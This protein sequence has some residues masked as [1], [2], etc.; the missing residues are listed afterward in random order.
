MCATSLTASLEGR[1]AESDLPG[2]DYTPYFFMSYAHTPRHDPADPDPD[3][4][5]VKF[6]NELCKYILNF[7]TLPACR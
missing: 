7:C 5:V 2:G 6:Y 3:E 1:V 4:D